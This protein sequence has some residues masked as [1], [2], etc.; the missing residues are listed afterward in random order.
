MGKY[1]KYKEY[2][3]LWKFI[4]IHAIIPSLS[5]IGDMQSDVGYK[6]ERR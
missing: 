3:F 5:T 6:R 1:M 4:F 2:R